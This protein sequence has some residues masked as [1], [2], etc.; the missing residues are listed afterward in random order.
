MPST[1]KAPVLAARRSLREDALNTPN[2]LTFGRVVLIPFVLYYL[3]FG[4]PRANFIAAM[5]YIASA[6]TDALDGWLARR[7]GLV[8]VLGKF[9]DPLADK[10]LVISILIYLVAMDRAPAWLVVLVVGRELSVTALRSIA[11]NEGVVLAAGQGGKE[12][13]ALQMVALLLLLLHF[14]YELNFGFT[15]FRIDFHETGLVLLYISVFLAL[16]SAGEYLRL[17]SQAVD[18]KLKRLA[19]ESRQDAGE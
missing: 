14:S 17:F 2:L 18:A 12:K 13:T 9:L 16:T 19:R 15:R 7:S 8:S 11:M 4:T 5:F 10:L 3:W 1:P 6:V